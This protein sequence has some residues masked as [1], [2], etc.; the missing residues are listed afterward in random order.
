MR[1]AGCIPTISPSEGVAKNKYYNF[2]QEMHVQ[3][4]SGHTPVEH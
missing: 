4:L 1:F 2:N 3:T